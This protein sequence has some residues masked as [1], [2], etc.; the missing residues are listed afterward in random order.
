M[1]P[2]ITCL[3]LP[4]QHWIYKG[5]LPH[6]AFVSRLWGSNSWTFYWLSHSASLLYKFLIDVVVGV[7]C[8]LYERYSCYGSNPKYFPKINIAFEMEDEKSQ[9]FE[10]VNKKLEVGIF[11]SF[12]MHMLII[13]R[14]FR[15]IAE[16]TKPKIS[17]LRSIKIILLEMSYIA[18]FNISEDSQG[19]LSISL[20]HIM[21]M[22]LFMLMKQW[23][24]VQWAAFCHLYGSQLYRARRIASFEWTSVCWM[25]SELDRS[26][27][28]LC[29]ADPVDVRQSSL[30]ERWMII[31][32]LKPSSFETLC[33]VRLFSLVCFPV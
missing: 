3:Q 20:P 17:Q 16:K 13:W 18:I 7:C 14:I 32:I 10:T 26:C 24:C 23:S 27:L 8:I 9:H 1:S 15:K 33:Q 30:A 29:F 6:S 4:S 11:Y 28:A 5:R 21:G 2:E 19:S 31:S 12:L 25:C 22:L